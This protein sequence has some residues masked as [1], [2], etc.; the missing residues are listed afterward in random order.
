[1]SSL[2]FGEIVLSDVQTQ[3]AVLVQQHGDTVQETASIGLRCD[4]WSTT[5]CTVLCLLT[6]SPVNAI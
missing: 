4:D 3:P 5:V 2:F 6:S 1:M